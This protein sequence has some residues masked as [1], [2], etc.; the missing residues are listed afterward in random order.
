MQYLPISGSFRNAYSSALFQIDSQDER[1]SHLQR[2]TL[3]RTSS[4]TNSMLFALYSAHTS[5]HQVKLRHVFIKSKWL[6]CTNTHMQAMVRFAGYHDKKVQDTCNN[7]EERF[8]S[9]TISCSF[10]KDCR[11]TIVQ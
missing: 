6:I 2:C 8:F 7:Y 5:P 9:F 4:L 11:S 1:V 10:E 3:Q